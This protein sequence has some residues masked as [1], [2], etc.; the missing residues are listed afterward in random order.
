MEAHLTGLVGS[1]R[2]FNGHLQRLL[3]DNGGD[4]DVFADVKHRTVTYLEEYVENVEPN[5]TVLDPKAPRG[6]SLYRSG[7][8]PARVSV[9]SP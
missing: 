8:V 3:R 2:Q 7:L 5:G 6:L 1:V 4:D 9:L